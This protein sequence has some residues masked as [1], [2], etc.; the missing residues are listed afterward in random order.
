M[1]WL[2]Q[3]LELVVEPVDVAT[4]TAAQIDAGVWTLAVPAGLLPPPPKAPP[5]PVGSCVAV[6]K[7]AIGLRAPFVQTPRQLARALRRRGAVP[8]LPDPRAADGDADG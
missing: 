3:A 8:V 6:V 4:W 2:D 5:L 7:H 1:T